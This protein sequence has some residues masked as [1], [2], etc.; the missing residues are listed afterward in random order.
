MRQIDISGI[1][2]EVLVDGR[3]AGSSASR[4]RAEVRRLAVDEELAL[5]GL[6]HAGEDLD[7]R[8]LAGAVVA[9]H[10]GHLAGA[11]RDARCPSAR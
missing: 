7:Q 4:G 6:V 5:V 11:A 1:I 3:D 8:R 9:E 10:A 2:A